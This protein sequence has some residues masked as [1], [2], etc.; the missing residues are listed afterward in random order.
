MPDD[1][2]RH[3]SGSLGASTGPEIALVRIAAAIAGLDENS[4]KRE[5]EAAI[6]QVNPAL[7]EEV[8]LQSYLFA[9]FPRALNAARIWR[10]FAAAPHP[11]TLAETGG[12]QE[13]NERGAITCSTVYGAAYDKLR[14]NIRSL[15]PLLD[16]WMI[17]DGYGKILSRPLLDLKLRELCIVAACAA[18]GQQRQL[19]SHLRGALNAG[20]DASAVEATLD[21]LADLVPADRLASYKLLFSRVRRGAPDVH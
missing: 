9:G 6:G 13:W 12:L 17:T 14:E 7:V 1:A 18:S 11:E 10:G 8:V 21:S 16:E 2:Q 5:M 20:V 19:H 15:H 4:V 3:E